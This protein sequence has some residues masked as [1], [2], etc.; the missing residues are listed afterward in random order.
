MAVPKGIASRNRVLALAGLLFS[1]LFLL[2]F[3][4]PGS[5]KLLAHTQRWTTASSSV[6][7]SKFLREKAKEPKSSIHHPIPKLMLDAK[8]EF[9]IKLKKQSKT[10]NEAIEEY[11]K[12]YKMNPPKG[13]DE[14]FEF[15]KKHNSIIIDEYDQ[16]NKDLK[17]FWLFSGEELR[18]RCIQVGFLP[19]VDLVRIENGQTRTIDVSKGF[20]DSEVGARAKGFRVMLEKFQDKLPNMDFPINEKAE[21]RIL[22]P[23]EEN[24]FSNLTADSTKGIEHVLGGEFIPDWRGDGNVWEAYRRTCEPSSQARRLFGSL[25]SHLKEGQ[26]PISRLADAGITSDTISEDFKFPSNVDD[27]FDFCDHPWAH[28]NQ[29]HFFSDWRTIHALYPMFSPAKGVG[30][31]DILIP[32]HYYFSST[33]RYTYGWD[34][35]NMVIKDV[36]EM[37][38]PWEE[39]SDDIFWRGAT[40]GGGSSP[41]GFLAQ[42]QRHRFIKM[43]SDTSDVNK[44]VVFADPPGTNNF[45]SAQVPI[46]QLNEDMMD[47]AFTKAVGCTQYPGGC[48]GMRKDHRF[49][50]AVP[51]GENWR[52]KYLIDVDGMGYSARLFA[53]LKSESAVLKSTVYT[54]FMSEWLQ[55]WLHYIPISQLY[56]ELYNVHAFFSGPSEA[57]LDASNATRGTYQA[58]GL[59]TKRLDGDAELRKIA[60]AGRDWMFTIGRKIDMEIYVYRLCLEWGRLTADDRE[61]MT[62]KD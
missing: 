10:L 54:E 1:L 8:E 59:T 49:A 19:S 3:L 40:T 42:Y 18:R 43:T 61:A 25:R 41:P 16:L 26:A 37:E 33:K 52:H 15:A 23:W 34:P 9:E 2:H 20:D 58:P 27:K 5:N 51:L 62:L 13:F 31:S 14:W 44:T 45:V 22:V 56:Q 35:V 30:Y 57:M 46:G 24:L 7:R 17:P 6:I 53:L 39:K 36:D 48:D 29:G 32:S 55:P 4:F 47:V 21:G 60:K 12:R 11:K 50:D 38:T 28:Y